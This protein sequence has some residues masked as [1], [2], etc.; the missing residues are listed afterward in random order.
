MNTHTS[1]RFLTRGLIAAAL[2]LITLGVGAHSAR[3]TTESLTYAV[4]SFAAAQ[5]GCS[6]TL[7]TRTLIV[8]LTEGT[9]QIVNLQAANFTVVA[10]PSSGTLDT[11]GTATRNVTINGVTKAIAQSYELVTAAPANTITMAND[12]FFL[13]PG[14]T[15]SLN[16]GALGIVDITPRAFDSNSFVNVDTGSYFQNAKATFLLHDVPAVP[17]AST[18][19]S[20]GLFLAGLGFAVLKARKRTVRLVG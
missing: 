18:F 17:E 11:N 10:S 5:A 16:L 8:A 19:G 6:F 3:A 7:N 20:F 2:G 12:S 4:T 9:P 13:S 1:S 14:S 15:T